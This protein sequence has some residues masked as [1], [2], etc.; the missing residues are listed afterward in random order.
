MDLAGGTG[1]PPMSVLVLRYSSAHLYALNIACWSYRLPDVLRDWVTAE[2]RATQTPAD[3][4]GL[5]ALAEKAA[6]LRKRGPRTP[7]DERKGRSMPQNTYGAA[8][9]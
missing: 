4:A 6:R 1:M 2:S 7:Q 9:H 8:V 5:L 3:L